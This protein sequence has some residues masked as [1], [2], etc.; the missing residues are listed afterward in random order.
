MTIILFIFVVNIFYQD[1]ASKCRIVFDSSDDEVENNNE[2][3]EE[4]AVKEKPPVK[5][6][7]D[8]KLHERVR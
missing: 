5:K 6:F 2:P 1:S 3:E 8:N 7:N 4:D